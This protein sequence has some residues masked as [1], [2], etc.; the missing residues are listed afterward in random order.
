M[1][2]WM[3]MPSIF[4]MCAKGVTTGGMDA[5]H[6]HVRAGAGRRA[7][8]QEDRLYRPWAGY[9]RPARRV[10][11]VHG[12]NESAKLWLTVLNNLKSRGVADIKTAA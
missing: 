3:V 11:H 9:G 1:A 6:F 12:E 10:G 8:C 7:D 5:I 2:K 4:S